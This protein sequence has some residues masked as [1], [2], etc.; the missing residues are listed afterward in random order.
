MLGRKHQ[1]SVKS[2][3]NNRY[4]LNFGHSEYVEKLSIG[5]QNGNEQYWIGCDR[6]PMV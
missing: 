6:E 2:L 1:E 5:G 4:K 3:L